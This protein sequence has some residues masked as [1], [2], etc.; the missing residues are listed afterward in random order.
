MAHTWHRHPATP[1]CCRIRCQQHCAAGSLSAPAAG[2][3]PGP[4][5]VQVFDACLGPSGILLGAGRSVLLVTSNPSFLERCDVVAVVQ[6]CG[7]PGVRRL[8]VCIVRGPLRC[9]QLPAWTPRGMARARRYLL[10][11]CCCTSQR[12]SHADKPCRVAT[13]HSWLL[14]STSPQPNLW[15]FILG[16]CA[17]SP[18]AAAFL[19]HRPGR[20]LRSGGGR[21]AALRQ[22]QRASA[23]CSRGFAHQGAGGGGVRL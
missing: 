15:R 14:A 8:T 21:P 4:R 13:C 9:S 17:M 22:R 23:C 11:T 16:L 10:E 1:V 3:H 5:L 12:D 19:H 2:L 7:V 6:V 18:T 20:L